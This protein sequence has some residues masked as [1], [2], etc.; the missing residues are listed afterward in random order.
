MEFITVATILLSSLNMHNNNEGFAYNV[1]LVD[2][3]VTSQVVY[4]S[5]NDGKYLSHHLKYNYTYDEQ[6]R[7]TK[8]EVLKW[9]TFSE[10]WER[11]HCL[12]YTYDMFGFTLAYA[13]WDTEK[14]DYTRIVAK[15]VYDDCMNGAMTVTL[16]K[17][18]NSENDWIVQ[19][20]MITMHPG[21][22]LLSSLEIVL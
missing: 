15:Q 22:N 21:D 16:Y 8:K 4:K 12:Y 17:W 6:N 19:N 14:T 10:S 13:L 2:N 7:L 5:I 18:N 11:S 3:A 1:E 9:D 20:N